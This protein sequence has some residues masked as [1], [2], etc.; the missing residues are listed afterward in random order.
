MSSKWVV[1]FLKAWRATPR[2]KG[3][4]AADSR[5]K[6]VGKQHHETATEA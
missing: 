2:D 4:Q 6:A 3:R 1:V 5:T